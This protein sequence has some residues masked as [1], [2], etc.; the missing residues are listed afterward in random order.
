[1]ELSEK[2]VREEEKKCPAVIEREGKAPRQYGGDEGEGR[3]DREDEHQYM[4]DRFYRK[5]SHRE[6]RTESS[7]QQS[8]DK[9]M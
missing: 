8:L 4:P 1:M 9:F 7:H 5:S 3:G 2:R 6:V